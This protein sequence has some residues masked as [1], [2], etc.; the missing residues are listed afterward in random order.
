MCGP[1]RG[2]GG[3]W[4]QSSSRAVEQSPSGSKNHSSADS[5][6]PLHQSAYL[7]LGWDPARA[8]IVFGLKLVSDGSRPL[9]GAERRNFT[10]FYR[11]LMFPD[12]LA[13]L[14]ASAGPCR[15]RAGGVQ[16]GAPPLCFNYYAA[17]G[18]LGSRS[19]SAVSSRVQTAAEPVPACTRTLPLSP[20]SAGNG[21]ITLFTYRECYYQILSST[22]TYSINKN[23]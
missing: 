18:N 22:A 8:Q 4:D 3:D 5:V 1:G 11:Q 7:H 23:G 2:P 15:G 12:D 19:R 13:S 16:G 14:Q 21:F 17:P 9:I 20:C 10:K 6:P